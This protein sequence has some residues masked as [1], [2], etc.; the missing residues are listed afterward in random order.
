VNSRKNELKSPSSLRRRS[1]ASV[2]S[3]KEEWENMDFDTLSVCTSSSSI[4][5]ERT[6]S[7][8]SC[9]REYQHKMGNAKRGRKRHRRVLTPAEI[10]RAQ[11][12][13]KAKEV[14]DLTAGDVCG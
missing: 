2:L 8:G 10:R 1:S 14:L 12:I 3:R 4:S 9:S 13:N 7:T 5:S 11:L 6:S